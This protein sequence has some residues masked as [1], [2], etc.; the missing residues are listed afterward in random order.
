MG[1]AYVVDLQARPFVESGELTRVLED[2]LP[3][4]EGY[5]LYFPGRRQVPS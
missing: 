1:I 5:F 4:Y 3:S 2:W